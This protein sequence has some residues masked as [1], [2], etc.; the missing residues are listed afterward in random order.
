M[1]LLPS[2]TTLKRYIDTNNGKRPQVYVEGIIKEILPEDKMGRPHQKFILN[3]SGIKVQIVHGL[4]YGRI[5]LQLGAKVKVCGEFLNSQEGLIH[6]TH[7]DPD[8][9]HPD[10]F[11]VLG[12]EVYGQ[13]EVR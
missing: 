13:T 9:R 12:G 7:F 1:E 6:W 2:V 11:I 5:P 3:V 4:D 10:G 8:A